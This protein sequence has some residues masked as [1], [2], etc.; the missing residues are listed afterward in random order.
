VDCSSDIIQPERK[1]D[2]Y[3]GM[4]RPLQD[5]LFEKGGKSLFSISLQFTINDEDYKPD[6]LTNIVVLAVDSGTV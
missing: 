2:S 4:Y 6:E 3:L 1:Y 5:V